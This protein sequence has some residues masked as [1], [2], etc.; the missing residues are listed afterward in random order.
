MPPCFHAT[1]RDAVAATVCETVVVEGHQFLIERPAEPE[2]VFLHPG[3]KAASQADEYL[4]HWVHLWPASRMLAVAIILEPW[5]SHPLKEAEAPLEV[6]ELGCGLG[7]AGLAALARGLR[8][9]FSDVDE[10]A[11]EF[12]ANNAH[13]NG[14]TAFNTLQLDFRSPPSHFTVPVAIA[15]DVLYQ[16]RLVTPLIAL[17]KSALAPGGLC[18]IADPNRPD[19]P[20]FRRQLGEAGFTV[21]SDVMTGELPGE[22]PMSGTLNRIACAKRKLGW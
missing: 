8:V 12:A 22:K 14:F 17:L 2:A 5:D 20:R 19:A 4:P 16:D 1:P 3:V 21:E 6:L 7:L 9:T 11:L 18:L 13:L 15:S 10:T